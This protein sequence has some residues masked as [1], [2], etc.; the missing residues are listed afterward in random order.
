M[1]DDHLR[2]VIVKTISDKDDL[3]EVLRWE[4][5][6]ALVDGVRR[7]SSH[8]SNI[9]PGA[10]IGNHIKGTGKYI[11]REY[12]K[13]ADWDEIEPNEEDWNEEL[14]EKFAEKNLFTPQ[15]KPFDIE[16]IA[17]GIKK[18]DPGISQESLNMI[19]LILQV[20]EEQVRAGKKPSLRSIES[21]ERIPIRRQR[22]NEYLKDIKNLGDD[23]GD[24][25]E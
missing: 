8:I 2:S 9:E 10:Y 23:L 16:K 20:M 22:I 19:K 3:R 5:V 1:K 25:I 17:E 6:M 15:S 11:L 7:Y 13:T 24:L 21:D 4:L 14:Q 18:I 12:L